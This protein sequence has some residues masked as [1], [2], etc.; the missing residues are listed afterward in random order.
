M[1]I[2]QLSKVDTAEGLPSDLMGKRFNHTPAKDWAVACSYIA[3]SLKQYDKESWE[4]YQTEIASSLIPVY[5]SEQWKEM[6]SLSLWAE[7]EIEDEATELVMGYD[8]DD[9]DTP[10]FRIVNAYLFVF[11]R[12]ATEIVI[13]YLN[14]QEEEGE[15]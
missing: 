14:D 2:E 15:E 3:D 5:Y 10:L 12:K 7:D 1:N 8:Y 9:R 13:E 6:N 11:Y 4:D